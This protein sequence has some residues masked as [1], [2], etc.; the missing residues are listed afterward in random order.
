MS[1]SLL[2]MN[3]RPRNYTF[4]AGEK[5]CLIQEYPYELSAPVSVNADGE[6]TA[7]LTDLPRVFSQKLYV[8]DGFLCS[9][10][11][12]IPA[13]E[14]VSI[15]AVA[16]LLGLKTQT[17]GEYL[18]LI[19]EEQIPPHIL[20]AIAAQAEAAKAAG[21]PVPPS[22]FMRKDPDAAFIESSLKNFEAT[23]GHLYR[24]F[25]YEPLNCLIPVRLY[26]PQAVAEAEK[27]GA[28]VPLLVMLHG[29]G[30]G[31][32]E[33]FW[34][35]ED[36]LTNLAEQYGVLV[37]VAD[38]CIR[39][40]SYGC[41]L[42]PEGVAAA[43]AAS[44]ANDEKSLVGKY[45]AEESLLARIRYYSEVYPVDSARI[46]VG[47]NSM[48]GMGSF[49]LGQQHPDLFAGIAPAAAAPQISAF[50]TAPL[51]GMPIYFTGGT[52]DDHGFIHLER[53]A[54]SM[55][56]DGLD[57][58]FDAVQGGTHGH[59]WVDTLDRWLPFLLAH[60]K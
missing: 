25:Y 49:Y 50:D 35:S 34:S 18:V 48:G 37:M 30:S 7:S 53:A 36:K 24:L 46:Y 26:V 31:V 8:E 32:D 56:A 20:Q 43:A 42:A 17:V 51:K 21:Q 38:G 33:I 10:E 15:P 58:T 16:G 23:Q 60:H 1:V 29:G 40:C 2:T 27:T 44:F 14:Q 52:E 12:K 41:K 6:L 19:R 4:R 5:M 55:I 11:G 9:E 13:A 47:G 22:P 3:W 28:K 57:L 54:K 39:N 45:H 59:A